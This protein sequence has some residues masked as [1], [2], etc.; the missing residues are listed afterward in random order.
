[1]RAAYEAIAA[2]ARAPLHDVA[3]MAII[4]IENA[5]L[6]VQ[7]Q[8]MPEPP[9]P[10][11]FNVVQ[12]AQAV[13]EYG[14]RYSELV[15]AWLYDRYRPTWSAVPAVPEEWMCR[16]IYVAIRDGTW[17]SAVTMIEHLM[18]NG[19]L[20]TTARV[21]APTRSRAPAASGQRIEVDAGTRQADVA[22]PRT[23]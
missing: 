18:C 5:F 12:V 15:V 3:L 2:D 17:E 23:Y 4:P 16:L 11:V 10:L 19:R 8:M 6:V 13:I 14:K 9:A 20:P 22:T 7:L 1:M 21:G